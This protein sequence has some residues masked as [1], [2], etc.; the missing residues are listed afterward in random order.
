M[1]QNTNLRSFKVP[2]YSSFLSE[3]SSLL[4]SL[5]SKAFIYTTTRAMLITMRQL[6]SA[7]LDPDSEMEKCIARRLPGET[8]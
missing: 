8:P 1:Q 3:V 4:P 7:F 5:S 6:R 2:S